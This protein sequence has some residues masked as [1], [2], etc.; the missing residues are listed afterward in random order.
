M[1]TGDGRPATSSD[2]GA[3]GAL[4]TLKKRYDILKWVAGIAL[5]LLGG[6][7]ATGVYYSRFQHFIVVNS[8]PQNM[9]AYF[10]AAE[11]PEG[12]NRAD[13]LRGR[14]VVGVDP[15]HL[16]TLGKTVG[17]ALDNLENRPAGRHSHTAVNTV[18]QANGGRD[19]MMGG[20]GGGFAD[21]KMET[22]DGSDSKPTPLKDGTNA[23]YIV[24]TA[25]R[26]PKQ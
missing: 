26:S 11:C 23:P 14:Y 21:P 3:F 17:A 1:N 24:L 15:S 16:D 8:I 6:A 9:I 20:G 22:S 7:F 5:G 10:I 18:P 25:C 13:E 4:E 2:G 19:R 12:W